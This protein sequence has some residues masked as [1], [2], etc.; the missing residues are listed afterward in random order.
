MCAFVTGASS[1]LGEAFACRLAAARPGP[2]RVPFPVM[3]ADEVAGAALAG[4]RLCEIVC[5]PGPPDPSLFDALARRSPRS[6]SSAVGGLATDSS[7]SPTVANAGSGKVDAKTQDPP[8][9]AWRR[10]A[11]LAVWAVPNRTICADH[12]P[13]AG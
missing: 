7:L 6:E 4:L 10:S 3:R 5:V 9:C 12:R 13:V 11:L 8:L 1:G 2:V